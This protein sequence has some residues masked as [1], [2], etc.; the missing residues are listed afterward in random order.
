[1][2][3]NDYLSDILKIPL[4]SHPFINNTMKLFN[5][6]DFI[7]LFFIC[8]CLVVLSINHILIAALHPE[9]QD[10]SLLPLS[11]EM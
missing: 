11:G 6:K 5:S 9:A 1:M 7:F 8:G 4:Y 3:V 10:T 2:I